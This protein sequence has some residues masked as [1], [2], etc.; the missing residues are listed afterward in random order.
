MGTLYLCAVGNAEGIRLALTI[1]RTEARWERIVLLDDAPST[2]G[3]LKLGLEVAGSFELLAR[4][5][6][7]RDQVVNLVTRTTQGR[8]KARARIASF[9]VPFASLVHPGVDLFGTELEE[10]TTIYP[11][12]S[13]GA[14]AHVARSSVVLLGGLVGHG[15][16]I[17]EGCV[18]APYAVINA[19]VKLGRGVYVGSNASILPDLTIGEGAT[20]AANTLVATDVPAGATVIGVPGMILGGAPGAAEP[21]PAEVADVAPSTTEPERGGDRDALETEIAAVMRE[22]L[23]ASSLDPSAS[24]FDAGGSSLR[25][26]QLCDALRAQLGLNVQVLDVYRHP[27]VRALAGALA[28]AATGAPLDGARRRAAMRRERGRR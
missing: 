17:G 12:A 13:I 21:A 27:S 2:H 10:E 22:V 23:G 9:G 14:E 28:G 20:I 15:A 3:T 25:A 7:A 4:A 19:R 24:F 11:M 6:P 1:Q 18:V 26:I 16:H 8:A 5:D